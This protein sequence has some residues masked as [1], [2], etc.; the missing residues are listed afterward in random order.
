LFKYNTPY[1]IIQI[2]GITMR[3]NTNVA[4]LT[5]LES[6]VQV[7]STLKDSLE[8]LSSGL[9]INKAS[10]DASGLAI[11]DKLRTQANSVSQAIDNA[12]SAVSLI[13]IADKAM[14]EQSNILDI[15]KQKLIQSATATTSEA[16]RDAIMKDMTK[17]LDQLQNISTQT[18]YNG[19]MLLAQE[20]GSATE[21]LT[22]Q[23]GE[24]GTDTMAAGSG[25]Q[26]NNSGFGT[27]LLKDLI[28]G[29]TGATVSASELRSLFDV[30]DSAINILN[31][32][33]ADFGSTQNQIEAALRNMM[34]QVTN[35]KA[36][37]SVIRD[38]D[39]AAESANFNKQNIIA[40][41]G[42]YAISQA[43]QVQ[44]NVLRLLQ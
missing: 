34:T 20:S 11:A 8:K 43:N 40:Q 41:A 36:A 4:S 29:A 7:N 35:I 28:S 23:M 24:T 26:A 42:T 30:V 39:Y 16:G 22:F 9:R 10:D 21:N 33:R 19:V 13:Q 14:A 44:Q 6:N 38:V 1:N 27:Q 18:N 17:L 2:K 32:W 25:V 37:E 31:T 12:N 5:A 3:I 15:V